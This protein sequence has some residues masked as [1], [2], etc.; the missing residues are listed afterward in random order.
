M[1]YAPSLSLSLRQQAI[2]RELASRG[3]DVLVVTSLP[4][5]LYLTNFTGS[6]AIVVLTADRSCSSRTFAT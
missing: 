5:I 6:S 3:L 1:S 4:N 2:R